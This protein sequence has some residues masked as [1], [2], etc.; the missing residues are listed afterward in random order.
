MC[1]IQLELAGHV[2][3]FLEYKNDLEVEQVPS[4]LLLVGLGMDM[5]VVGCQLEQ[6]LK[7]CSMHDQM[8]NYKQY[9]WLGCI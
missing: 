3:D 1:S 2:V 9:I 8:L 6:H 7:L 4:F 5:L